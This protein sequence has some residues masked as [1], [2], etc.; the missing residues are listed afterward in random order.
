MENTKKDTGAVRLRQFIKK[1]MGKPKKK[2]M[3][4]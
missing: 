3:K 4:S 1:D 2:V